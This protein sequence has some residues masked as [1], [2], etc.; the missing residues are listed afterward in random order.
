M[1]QS[2]GSWDV[3]WLNSRLYPLLTP[4]GSGIPVFGFCP[5]TNYYLYDVFGKFSLASDGS[6]NVT[7]SKS[8][9]GVD[10]VE[11]FALYLAAIQMVFDN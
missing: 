5:K 11:H 4:N 8:A 2:R 6:N 10:F 9:H 3:F 7:P 1:G